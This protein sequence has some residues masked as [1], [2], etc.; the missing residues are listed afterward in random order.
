MSSSKRPSLE[1]TQGPSRAPHR[2]MLRAVGFSDDDFDRPQIGVA[3]SWNEVTPC[4][5]G[6]DGLEVAAKDG[7]AAAGGIG[8]RFNTIAVSDAIAMGHEGMR[9]SL[10]T[11]EVIADSVE[12]VAFAEGFDGL[13]TLAGCD[14]SLPGMLMAAARLDRPSVFVYGGTIMPGR[15]NG[16]DVTIQ[17]VFEAVGAHAAGD[18][19]DA[20]LDELEHNACPGAGSCGGMFTANTMAAIAEA[21]GMS[22]PRSASPPAVDHRRIDVARQAGE[23]AVA[24]VEA[25]LRPSKILTKAAF[26]NAIA[27]GLALGGSTN[28]VLHLLAIANEARVDLELEDFD[29]VARRTPVMADLKPAGQYVMYDLDQVGG[30]PAVMIELLDAGLINGDCLT[31][32][33]RTVAE[34]LADA[35]RDDSRRVVKTVAEPIHETG[36]I[37]ILRGSLAPDGAV[38]KVVGHPDYTFR[39]PARVFDDEAACFEAV[40]GGGIKAGE[41]IVIRNEG[42]RGGPGMREMLAVTAAVSGQGLG[43]DVALLTDGRFSGAT[44]GLMIAHVAPE[45]VDGGPIAVVRDGDMISIDVPNRRLDVEIDDE[46]LKARFEFWEPMAPR[47]TWGALAKYASLVSSSATGAVCAPAFHMTGQ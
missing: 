4:N 40:T 30:V 18:M 37:V 8:V 32:T 42:P 45:S 1:V 24:A 12:L 3:S 19:S 20:E 21:L 6:L 29:R 46:E 39:G 43:D 5:I 27:V 17:D 11:R 41:V 14:K 7:V 28:M 31:I 44:H 2:A 38:A 36:G 15:V 25:E 34:N 22:A 33:G 10:V 16:K 35:T 23:L 9:A 26:E 47:Y 13:V